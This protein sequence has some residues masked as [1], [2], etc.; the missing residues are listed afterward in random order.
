MGNLSYTTKTF[1]SHTTRYPA[2]MVLELS[3]A[4][5]TQALSIFLF[6]HLFAGCLTV[7]RWLL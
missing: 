1:F 4:M 2:F 7:I 6:C 3:N 5:Y